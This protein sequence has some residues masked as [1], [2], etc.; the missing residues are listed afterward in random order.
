MSKQVGK[1]IFSANVTKKLNNKMSEEIR[2]SVLGNSAM[3]EEMKRIFQ[4]ANRRAQNIE[5][6]GVASPAYQALILEGRTGYSKF[7]ISGVD[8]ST[9]YGWQQAKYEYS[10]AIEYLNNPTSSATGARQYIKY[11]ANKK[12][13]EL[14]Y[15][16]KKT[17]FYLPVLLSSIFS[18]FA[19]F[20]VVPGFSI[21]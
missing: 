19:A 7:N 8:I 1:A 16:N 21:P 14:L 10:K 18:P 11:L 5:K 15:I 3:K 17:D 9:E 13:N 6:S 20:S 12:N 2:K 4:Q